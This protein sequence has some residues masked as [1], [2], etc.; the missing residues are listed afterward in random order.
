MKTFLINI[1]KLNHE[2]IYKVGENAEDND[3]IV[4]C[5]DDN[6]YWFHVGNNLSSCH[7]TASIPIAAIDKKYKKFIITQGAILCKAHSKYKAEKG[8][9]INFT[10]VKNVTLTDIPGKV[11]ISEYN[12][13]KI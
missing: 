8:L 10:K 11:T 9:E 1:P 13:I 12:M 2:V 7:V 4:M 3:D 5:A 6:D